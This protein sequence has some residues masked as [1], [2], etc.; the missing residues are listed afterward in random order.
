MPF[1]VKCGSKIDV[2]DDYMLV[3]DIGKRVYWMCR[4]CYETSEKPE[5][6]NPGD[7]VLVKSRGKIG[8]YEGK[9]KDGRCV[10]WHGFKYG[11]V[12]ASDL[13]YTFECDLIL[14]SRINDFMEELK[15]PALRMLKQGDC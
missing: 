8:R 6:L 3:D 5:N 4:R 14:I 10:V 13:T 2:A 9:T 12:H 15:A 7:V 11:S 1:C